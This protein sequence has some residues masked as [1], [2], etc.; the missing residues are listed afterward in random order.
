M[1]GTLNRATAFNSEL[2]WDTSSVTTMQ[3]TFNVANAFNSELAWENL[4]CV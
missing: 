2:D 3:D 1:V 4:N